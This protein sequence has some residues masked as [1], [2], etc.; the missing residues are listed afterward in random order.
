MPGFHVSNAAQVDIRS[1]GRYTQRQWGAAQRRLY[2]SG[3]ELKFSQLAKNPELSPE[4]WEFVPPV[5]IYN[6]EKHLV[7]YIP[8]GAGILVIRVQSIVDKFHAVLAP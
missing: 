5:R 3:L 8:E 4:R 2:L 1:I 6:Y 7:V